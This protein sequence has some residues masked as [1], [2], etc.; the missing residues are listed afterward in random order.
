MKAG[1]QSD[2]LDLLHIIGLV[3]AD[4][5]FEWILSLCMV[6]ALGAV[7]APLFILLGLQGGIIGNMLDELQK[8]PVSRLVM[9]KW[10]TSLDEA[11]LKS[12][13]K[14]TAALIES[15]AAFL[16]LDVEGMKDTVNVLPASDNDPLLKE[17]KITL[18]NWKNDL[19]L[20]APLAETLRKQ[21]G[22]SITLTL[23]RSTGHEER[24]PV[25]MQVAGVLPAKASLDSKIW[26]DDRL[27]KQLH[28]WRRGGAVPELGLP[29]GGITLTP[30]YDG[31]VTLL[32]RVPSDAEYRTMIGRGIGFSQLPE[33]FAAT[34]WGY[35]AEQQARLWKPINSRVFE[36]NF[37]SLTNRHHE[38]GYQL[39]TLPYIDDFKVT[40]RS[41]GKSLP[42]RLS[43]LLPKEKRKLTV[44]TITWM[45][46]FSG[47]SRDYVTVPQKRP[48]LPLFSVAK[49]TTSYYESDTVQ[50][51]WVSQKDR[52]SFPSSKAEMAFSTR[53]GGEEIIIPVRVHPSDSVPLGYIAT[54]PD[55]AGKMNAAR[56][57]EAMY[58]PQA[59]EF[60]PI[61]QR[62][63]F[64]RAYAKSIDDLEHLVE[65]IRAQGDRQTSE[66]LQKPVSRIAEVRNIRQLAGYMEKLYLLILAVSGVSGFFAILA[67]V[68]AGIQRKR[69]DIAYLQLY[70]LHPVSLVLFPFAKSLVLVS[71]ALASAFLAYEIFSYWTDRIFAEA[72]GGAASLTR[73][74]GQQ[75][76]YLIAALYGTAALASLIAAVAV[77]RI[78]PGEY[79]RE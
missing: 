72:L 37:I 78:E 60:R 15:P 70:G 14:Q 47:I 40:L 54:D 3:F 25:R 30:E 9:P 8:D 35:A 16:L 29:G 45:R 13:R 28:Q 46:F 62:V 69:K 21:Q 31:I 10:E 49:K 63:R 19:V 23:I 42:L 20:S 48:T 53:A 43:A 22:D 79:I 74:D 68:Y 66:A 32:E 56:R 7:F 65:F 11:W 67:N 61:E 18:A 73:I 75:V 50:D 36:Q 27:F 41:G 4:L 77:T 52:I 17:N 33:P 64:F 59:G 55:F 34:S 39:E 26:L 5:R 12:L 2:S 51:V 44:P 76:M 58:D 57:Q 1:K 6:L 38:M 24:R 71:A